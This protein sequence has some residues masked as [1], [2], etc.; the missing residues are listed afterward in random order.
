MDNYPQQYRLVVES[1]C[2]EISMLAKM[3]P[4]GN[5]GMVVMDTANT[6]M[7]IKVDLQ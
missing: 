2:Y 5:N 7:A 6:L 3:D 1:D 4:E